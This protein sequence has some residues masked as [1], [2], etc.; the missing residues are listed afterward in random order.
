MNHAEQKYF[1]INALH[2]LDGQAGL[3]TVPSNFVDLVLTDPP[4]GIADS[5]KLTKK[6]SKIVTTRQAWGSDFQDSWANI[7][8]YY[9][10]LKP[11][12]AQFVRVLKDNGSMILFLDRKY[13][14]LIVHYLERDFHLNF[15]NKI[16]F[17]KLNA[18]PSIRKVNYRS[19]IE[20]CV[21]LTKGKQYTF[22]FGEQKDM[23][24]VF[25]GPIGRKKTK[26]PTE[27]YSWMIEPLIKIHS[28]EGDV[29]LDAFAGSATTLVLAKKH[30]RHAIG[31]EK[32]PAMYEMAKA[33]I[34]AE[35]LA[36]DFYAPDDEPAIVREL[37][38][39]MDTELADLVAA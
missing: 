24:Q 16:Y 33:R 8:D 4:Y 26:H 14:G 36:F 20:E 21:F 23:T 2:N 3:A 17:K 15:K 1:G 32:S 6:G 12:I 37:D 28:K 38:R 22:N 35:Q 34:E 18:V 5:S 31:F 9:Q 11:F 19:S 30:N 29:V 7:D 27:K 39:L 13:T 25:E 10:W